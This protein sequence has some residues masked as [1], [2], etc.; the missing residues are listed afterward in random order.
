MFWFSD[1]KNKPRLSYKTAV[2]RDDYPKAQKLESEC[3]IS[4][5]F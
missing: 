2:L 5:P 4:G 1:D 3:P